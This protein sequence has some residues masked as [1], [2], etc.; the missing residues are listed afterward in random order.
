M[1]QSNLCTAGPSGKKSRDLLASDRKLCRP[2]TGL[3]TGHYTLKWHIYVTGLSSNVIY[4]KC[5]QEE[6]SSYHIL[7]QC[8]ALAGHRMKIFGPA[9]L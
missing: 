4:R 7:R 2:V 9:W 3:L 1:R 8:P 6:E 5:G